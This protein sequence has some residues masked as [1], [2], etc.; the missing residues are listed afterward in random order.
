MASNN[1]RL[2]SLYPKNED[3]TPN[4]LLSSGYSLDRDDQGYYVSDNGSENGSLKATLE[5]TTDPVNIKNVSKYV[6]DWL[7]PQLT[8]KSDESSIFNQYLK[9]ITSTPGDGGWTTYTNNEAL[10][11]LSYIGYRGRGYDKS[12]E[13]TGFWSKQ[14]DTSSWLY[15]EVSNKNN[16]NPELLWNKDQGTD[17][18]FSEFDSNA[19][20]KNIAYMN[21]S[22]E[23]KPPLWYPSMLYTY[24]VKDK[25]T[26]YPGP[27]LMIKPGETLELDFDNNINIAGLTGKQAQMASMVENNSYGLNGGAMA[28]GMDSTN[29]HMHGGHVTPTG[30][31]D[32]VVSRYTT[33]Q[34]WTTII[35]IPDQ[36]GIGSYWYHPHFHPAVNTQVYGGLSGFMQ[37]GNPLELVPAFKDVPRNLGV[38]K[39]MQVG[40]D[41]NSG[42]YTLA[43]VNGNII[44]QK[45]LAA[46]RASM[47]TI[48]GE[49]Q[50]EVDLKTGG[51]QSFSFSNQDNNYYMNLAIRHQQPDGSWN[52]LPLY[53]YGEDGHQYPQ[54]RPASQNVLGY[55]QPGGNTPGAT[56]TSYEQSSNLISLPSG[57]RMDLLVNLPAGKSELI[58]TYSFEGKNGETFDINS[59][60]F[61]PDQY[62]ELSNDNTDSSN[63]LS[64]PG[65]IATFNVGG[66]APALDTN[67]LNSFVEEA[68]KQINVQE[69]TPQT[70]S[71]D[72]IRNSIPSVNLFEQD[73]LN[74]DIWDPTRKREFNYQILTL[75][76]P[77]DQRDIPTQKAVKQRAENGVSIE[78]YGVIQTSNENPWL[79]YV[80]PDLIN[81]HVFPQGPLVI[82][83]L[84]TMEEW[85]LKNWNWGGKDFPNGGFFTSH[86]FHIHVNDY[87]VKHSDNELPNKRA[88]EDVTQL[89]SSGYNYVTKDGT[90]VTQHQ[91]DPLAGN[92]VPIDE[93]LNPNNTSL[94]TTGY[95]DTTIRMLYQ[96]YLGTF[97]HH[98]HLLEHEDAGMMQVVSVIENTDS[99]WI[100]PSES[101][102]SNSS[103]LL[104]R[105]ADSLK[106]VTLDIRSS[107][108]NNIKRA[109][110]GDISND[111]VQDII[112]SFSGDENS[113][114]KVRI[115]DGS[116]LKQDQAAVVL[117]TLTPYKNSSL[118]P[119]SFNSDFTG[120]GKRDLI[121]AG[122]VNSPDNDNLV[123]LS[124][125]ELIG[126]QTNDLQSDWTNLYS[127]RPWKGV[128]GVNSIKLE[129]NSTAFGVGD[130]NLDNFD[131]YANAYVD[132]G[133]LRLRIIDGAS[134]ALLNQTGKFEGGYL[135]NTNILS[136]IEYTSTCFDDLKSLTISSGF[137]SYAQSAIENLIVTAESNSGKSHVLTFQLNSGHFIA[138]GTMSDE[139]EMSDHGGDSNQAHSAHQG[140]QGHQIATASL[141]G[142]VKVDGSFNLSLTNHQSVQ[143]GSSSATPTFAGALANGALIV[144]DHLVF[145]QGTSDG[146][147]HIGNKS[148]SHDMYNSTQDLYLSL[149]GINQVSRDDLTGI[150]NKNTKYNAKNV[151]KRINLTM[152]AFQAYT[153]TMIKPSD[154]AKLSIADADN[155]LNPKRLARKILKEYSSQVKDFYGKDFN[156][157]SREEITDKTFK[158]L[159]NRAPNKNE[160]REWSLRDKNGIHK[161][162]LPME[163]LR[164]TD[165]EDKYRVAL[166]SAASKWSQSQWGTNA[167]VDG[168]FGQ[169]LISEI[170]TFEKLSSLIIDSKGVQTWESANTSFN[171]YQDDVME[172]LNGTPI[173]KTGF[174]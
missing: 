80:N 96:D 132:N 53:I 28:G 57:K 8:N 49:Y 156:D 11:A 108:R 81:D 78:K 165:G 138:T 67:E 59:L 35:D 104:L 34:D 151:D 167:I 159:Y 150:I 87:Q 93:A 116:S 157:M 51:W 79:G 121:T 48:N 33:G 155:K 7:I 64:G 101:F 127:Y 18:V 16:Y 113:A 15:T 102:T 109:Q 166:L 61:Q 147:Y 152:L 52:V 14:S 5:I 139:S 143:A 6:E 135:P 92:F 145:S 123:K 122:F 9:A 107:L 4:V 97:V 65:A 71:E 42:K 24:G 37:V 136:D 154:L 129:S 56:A 172:S 140:H 32:N 62:V 88:L 55:H 74:N 83:Q 98:C 68:N 1:F 168:N 119:W 41:E 148:S 13:Q 72:Y 128:S 94:F 126:W 39:T 149:K 133:T 115:Y 23:E 30:F 46:N 3:G 69:I 44:G 27:V 58:T 54:I 95:N 31:G 75:V 73:N 2:G 91:L 70:S 105:E 22:N 43:S 63:P 89:N 99:S 125:L 90:T 10:E 170:S 17:M 60:R 162:D 20:L 164:K 36:H 19:L 142:V 131:D 29:F 76:G 106:K 100:I 25:G 82:G 153:N 47:F 26:S 45:S 103:G 86:P 146:E 137:N 171:Q 163:I 40:I 130:Y 174:F 66:D 85:T 118:S 77:E 12:A 112:L 84:G 38:I 117:S 144:D 110:V 124:D 120:D 169:G 114:G 173:S 160:L 21:G 134:V 158:T 141:D 111:F 50:P 161:I